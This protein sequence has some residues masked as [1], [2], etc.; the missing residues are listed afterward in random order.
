MSSRRGFGFGTN[1]KEWVFFLVS[2][3]WA[4]KG[5]AADL[6]RLKREKICSVNW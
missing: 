6:A 5:L 2:F 1:E 4:S 3:S